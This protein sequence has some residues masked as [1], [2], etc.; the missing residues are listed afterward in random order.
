VKAA[1]DED[2]AASRSAALR[3]FSASSLALVSAVL[4]PSGSWPPW[5]PKKFLEL[6]QLAPGECCQFNAISC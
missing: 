3:A 1:D 2:A 4:R 5:T 6:P